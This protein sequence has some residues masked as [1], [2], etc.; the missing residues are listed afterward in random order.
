MSGVKKKT[1]NS[2]SV[3]NK[4]SDLL[5]DFVDHLLTEPDS[6]VSFDN[7][8]MP[9][10]EETPLS[11]STSISFSSAAGLVKPLL[12]ERLKTAQNLLKDMPSPDEKELSLNDREQ[13]T[14]IEKNEKQF[15]QNIALKPLQGIENNKEQ[16]KEIELPDLLTTPVLE[17]VNEDVEIVLEEE[18]DLTIVNLRESV[19]ELKTT[20]LP[21]QKTKNSIEETTRSRTTTTAR[22]KTFSGPPAWAQQE[23][24]AL[25]FNIGELKLAVPLIK[26]GGI[27]R[28]DPEPTPMA[29]R[30][31][32]Y[33]GLVAGEYGNVSLIDTALWIMPEKYDIAKAKGLNY[34]YIVLLDDTQWGLACSSVDDA[35]TLTENQVK[36]TP[37][38]SKRPWLAGMMVDEMCALL[39]VDSL[40]EMLDDL[41][42]EAVQ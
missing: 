5:Q 21:D 42:E 25:T 1:A 24:Q 40:I 26:L 38:G 14:E 16:L 8:E 13:S 12:S 33:L 18:T 7:L 20:Q 39:D 36:W 31:P 22:Y 9:K 28:I 29:G 17:T 30:P 23:F 34:E 2:S 27:H 15:E 37:K 41:S 32:W 10:V 19:P 3:T 35:L 6:S 11:S 4:S